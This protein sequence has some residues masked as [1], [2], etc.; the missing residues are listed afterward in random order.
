MGGRPTEPCFKCGS[1]Y[2]DSLRDGGH[3]SE[4]HYHVLCADCGMRSPG[5][6]SRHDVIVWWNKAARRKEA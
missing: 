1:Q 6:D 4:W 3:W 2:T 5:F